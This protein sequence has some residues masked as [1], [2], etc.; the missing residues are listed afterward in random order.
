MQTLLC[1][2]CDVHDFCVLE[3]VIMKPGVYITEQ[4]IQSLLFQSAPTLPFMDSYNPKAP[5][6]IRKP[7][8]CRGE[9]PDC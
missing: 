1:P 6:L 7:R 8:A 5:E 4:W 9:Q 2:D 3:S